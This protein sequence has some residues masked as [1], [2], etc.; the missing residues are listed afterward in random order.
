[1]GCR[2]PWRSADSA[3]NPRLVLRGDGERS[4][5]PSERAPVG[6]FAEPPAPIAPFRPRPSRSPVGWKG[7]LHRDLDGDA[8]EASQLPSFGKRLLE[9]KET[10]PQRLDS[11][12]VLAALRQMSPLECERK[13]LRRAWEMGNRGRERSGWSFVQECSGE[14]DWWPKRR[15]GEIFGS[16][17]FRAWDTNSSTGV[18][19]G[20]QC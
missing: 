20:I 14:G 9:H 15:I 16:W 6:V 18:L 17:E 11:V 1:M 10:V 8:D 3:E 12:P 7:A 5:S 4:S 2:L 19:T 13:A